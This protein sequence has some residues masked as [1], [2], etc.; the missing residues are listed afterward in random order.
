M[1]AKPFA[2]LKDPPEPV[3]IQVSKEGPGR[4][5]WRWSIWRGTN[6]IA[7][8]AR[9]FAGAEAAYEEGRRALNR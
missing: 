1:L 8:A 7:R 2:P 4:N 3:E 5:S 9:G 6:L